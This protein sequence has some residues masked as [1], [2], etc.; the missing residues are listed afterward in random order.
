MS[1]TIFIFL[2]FLFPPNSTCERKHDTF[3]RYIFTNH[4]GKL[5]YLIFIKS[6]ILYETINK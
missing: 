1:I 6:I 2:S 4:N 3:L 5:T